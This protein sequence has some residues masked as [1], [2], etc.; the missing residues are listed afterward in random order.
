MSAVVQLRFLVVS[1][2]AMRIRAIVLMNGRDPMWHLEMYMLQFYVCECIFLFNLCRN[3]RQAQSRPNSF[4][5]FFC[6]SKFYSIKPIYNIP[7]FIVWLFCIP[8]RVVY[9]EKWLI[10]F[11]WAMRITETSA[12]FIIILCTMPGRIC[13]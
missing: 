3:V 12:V 6:Y 13:I 2:E 8:F 7:F 10:S 1:N 11:V 4:I 9:V 5:L